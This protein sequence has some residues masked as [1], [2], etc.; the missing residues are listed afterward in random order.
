MSIPA[1]I[2]PADITAD[3]NVR[4]D[5]REIAV[6]N[7]R[8]EQVIGGGANGVV[9]R[10]RHRYLNR[11]V[12]L[13]LW[14]KRRLKDR[15]DKFRQGIEEARKAAEAELVAGSRAVRVLEA[16]EVDGLFFAVTEYCE[17]ITLQEWLTSHQWTLG[18]RYRIA[19]YL[20]ESVAEL[21]RAHLIH[22]DLHTKNILMPTKFDEEEVRLNP[23]VFNEI[24]IRIVDFGTSVFTSRESSTA[25]HWRVFEETLCRILAPVCVTKLYRAPRPAPSMLDETCEWYLDFLRQVPKL[26][27]SAGV[28]WIKSGEPQDIDMDEWT[29][30]LRSGELRLEWSFLGSQSWPDG[31]CHEPPAV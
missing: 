17:G 15:R 24:Q 22:G 19:W 16:G 3:G 25:R 4:I 11:Q 2:V 30:V 5:N 20:C 9:F 28:Y 21:C 26:L 23:A 6:P 1:D 13:K 10:A 14:F 8:I 12:A 18:F 31:V 7:Y 29:G 27:A